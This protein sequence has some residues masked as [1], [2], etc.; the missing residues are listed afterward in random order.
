MKKMLVVC[1]LSML[2]LPVLS[3]IADEMPE[4]FLHI[5]GEAEVLSSAEWKETYQ[6]TRFVLTRA[7]NG[8]NM[9][10]CF[11]GKNGVWAEEFCTEQ[12]VPQGNTRTVLHLSEGAWNFR[13][14]QSG[15]G[16]YMEGP[17]LI[18]LQYSEDDAY[19]EWMLGFARSD[20]GVW[21]L[22][23]VRNHSRSVTIDI[24]SE[25]LRYYVPADK[26]LS[27]LVGCVPCRFDRDL[28]SFCLSDVPLGFQQAQDIAQT[29]EQR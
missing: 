6:N 17:I 26:A 16:E 25:T 14:A 20:T 13:D 18:V 2:L 24:D 11:V 4:T 27:V 3:A 5:L 8:C 1:L 28:R 23:A 12:A 15:D 7:Q 19:V 21:E 29:L 10:Y 9:L 22:V